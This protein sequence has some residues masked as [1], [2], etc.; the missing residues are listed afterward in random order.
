MEVEVEA[1]S[2]PPGQ[3]GWS[4]ELL[5][6]GAEFLAIAGGAPGGNPIENQLVDYR[7]VVSATFSEESLS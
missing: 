1:G 3:R 2:R 6:K 4:L 5:G 7:V